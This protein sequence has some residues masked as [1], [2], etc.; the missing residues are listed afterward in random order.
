MYSKDTNQR[1]EDKV[2]AD[3]HGNAPIIESEFDGELPIANCQST[4][5]YSTKLRT[6]GQ[7][8]RF[9]VAGGGCSGFNYLFDLQKLVDVRED[10]EYYFVH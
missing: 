5:I 2:L 8:F 7:L 9:G 10:D 1:L 4:N 3:F 6:E